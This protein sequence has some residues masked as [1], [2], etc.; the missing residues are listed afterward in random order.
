M[1][2]CFID[3]IEN[4]EA[5]TAEVINEISDLL[6]ICPKIKIYGKL[7]HQ[8]RDVG[9]FSDTI[10][11]FNYSGTKTNSNRLTSNLKNMLNIINNHYSANF[12]GIL[13][14]R[15]NS[16]TDYISAHSDDTKV[17]DDNAGV[18]IISFGCQRIL[19]FRDKLTKKIV[20]NILTN[21]NE[22]IQMNAEQ[23]KLFTHE[24]PV[25]KNKIGVRYSFT[26]RCHK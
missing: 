14:N 12:N 19:R 8:N 17:Y 6:M 15:Y 4:I 2:P 5:V 20:R 24:I 22:I 26:F 13:I 7:C 11:T 25:E 23:Q 18:I 3:K 10:D 9:F 1:E 16:G 21:N